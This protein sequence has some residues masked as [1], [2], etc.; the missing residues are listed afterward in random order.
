MEKRPTSNFSKVKIGPHWGRMVYGLTTI[1]KCQRIIVWQCQ[2]NTVNANGEEIKWKLD[3]T[4]N[5]PLG[6]ENAEMLK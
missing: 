4:F 5:Q 6:N 1:L 3:N 2:N